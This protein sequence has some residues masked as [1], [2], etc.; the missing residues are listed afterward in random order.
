M[1][2][3]SESELIAV[4]NNLLTTS[5]RLYTGLVPFSG[6]H[7]LQIHFGLFGHSPLDEVEKAVDHFPSFISSF[8]LILKELRVVDPSVIL[9]LAQMFG[10]F[11]LVF[12][13]LTAKQRARNYQ[14]ITR[15]FVVLHVKGTGFQQLL[16]KIVYNGLLLTISH[17]PEDERLIN[18]FIRLPTV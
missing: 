1:I 16:D 11:F 6:I 13:N 2:F 18:R 12:P 8:A 10:R 3:L 7:C 9:Y 15:L 17:L 14:A 5:E 4:L